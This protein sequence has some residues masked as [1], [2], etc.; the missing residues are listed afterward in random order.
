MQGKCWGVN[1]DNKISLAFI[2]C[3]SDITVDECCVL[4]MDFSNSKHSFIKDFFIL[5][6]F[7]MSI[8][9]VVNS[10]QLSSPIK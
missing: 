4:H 3:N 5:L 9:R 7:K 10:M 6:S 8:S 1:E 2:E